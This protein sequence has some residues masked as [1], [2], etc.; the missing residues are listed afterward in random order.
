MSPKW[1][2]RMRGAFFGLFG[3]FAPL[4]L[5]ARIAQ[6]TEP[7]SVT[8]ALRTLS[9]G[10]VSPFQFSPDGKW[11]AYMV[12]DNKNIE[13]QGTDEQDIY[14]QTG[15]YKRNQAGS[16][17]ITNIETG[18]SE[19]LTHGQGSNW[20]PSWSPNGRYLAFLSDRNG[21]EARLWVWDILKRRIRRISNASIRLHY[22]F[23]RIVWS[24]DSRQ[25]LV[26]TVPKDSSVDEFRS[27]VF[28]SASSSDA[29]QDAALGSTIVLY[30]ETSKGPH[31]ERLSA[32]PLNLE[33]QYLHDLVLIEI[34][35]G[36]STI[37][38]HGHLVGWYSISPNGARVAYAV[39]TRIEGSGA[40]QPILSDVQV[41]EL[42]A[43]QR[44]TVATDVRL[45]GF[46]WSPDSA[47]LSYGAYGKDQYKYDLYVVAPG[48]G[49]PWRVSALRDGSYCCRFRIPIWDK[50][51]NYFYSVLDGALWRTSVRDSTTAELSRIPRYNIRARTSDWNGWLWT[52]DR[53]KATV[54]L[55][56][57]EA[58]KQDTFYRI[59]LSTGHSTKLREEGFCYTCKWSVDIGS[60]LTAVSSNGEKILYVAENAQTPPNLWVSD[61][62]FTNPR[63]LTDLNPQF[64][65]YK[66][67]SGSL[68]H[69]LDDGTP[70]QGALLLPSD[71]HPGQR[72]P[73]VVYVYPGAN[74]SDNLDE[75]AFGEFPGPFDFQL[76]ATRGYA[77]LL[78]D[79]PDQTPHRLE[80]LTKSVLAGVNSVIEMGVA[81]PQKIGVMG[82]S[83]GGYAALGLI[84]RSD[85][86]KAAIAADGWGDYTAYF[87]AMQR[88]GSSYESGQA[89]KRLGGPPWQYP[90]RYV[91][92]SPVYY[93]DRVRT[94]LLLV[95]ASE[96]SDMPLF[97]SDEVFVGLRRLGKPVAYAIYKGEPHV[98]SDWSYANQVD[99]A[100]R[101]INW[102]DKYLKGS[103]D[104]GPDPQATPNPQ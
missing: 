27:R 89:E 45:D 59:D 43:M 64:K 102:F 91:E 70:R 57:D 96:D 13:S 104:Q 54:V 83:Q 78:P 35:T 94:P 63:Q 12:R 37:L 8:D 82:H 87:G 69:W 75:F 68:V 77:I 29:G 2:Q 38:D 21:G 99:L 1:K 86:F 36:N 76:L 41:V 67:G 46:S 6:K 11:A 19:D 7:L 31:N 74:L 81:D 53:D 71:Y 17:W 50:T 20:E 61:P 90:M 65:K 16:I 39:P 25:V 51:G 100:N 79:A 22:L 49:S 44:F 34:E 72:Y 98:P 97:L 40:W 62:S 28:R 93:L 84:V 80:G 15:V 85:R 18:V 14:I 48:H 30:D 26:T 52:I 95:H 9:F 23:G 10:E 55:A 32:Q 4:L 73:L 33:A 101:V 3:M 92:N 88:D 42:A 5:N 47:L 103:G 58:E 56:H 66:M 24:P 60:F